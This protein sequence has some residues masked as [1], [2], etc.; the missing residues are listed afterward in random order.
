MT[1]GGCAT[2]LAGPAHACLGEG[3]R[4]Q[5]VAQPMRGSGPLPI[6]P[7]QLHRDKE[8]QCQQDHGDPYLDQ[9]HRPALLLSGLAE[10]VDG[11]EYE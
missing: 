6:L 4:P 3:P 10:Q 5:K 11:H 8:G 2:R 1:L 9:G 7:G